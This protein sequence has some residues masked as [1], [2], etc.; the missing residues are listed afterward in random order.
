VKPQ[1]KHSIIRLTVVIAVKAVG[2]GK[3]GGE[4]KKEDKTGK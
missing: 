3:E 2:E 4:G 1:R